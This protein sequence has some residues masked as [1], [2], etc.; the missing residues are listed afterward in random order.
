MKIIFKKIKILKHQV[1]IKGTKN[2][3]KGTKNVKNP[4]NLTIFHIF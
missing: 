3:T 1:I 2:V 4:K